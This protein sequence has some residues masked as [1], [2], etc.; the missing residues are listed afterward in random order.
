MARKGSMGSS[1]G[2]ADKPVEKGPGAAL[3]WRLLASL[4]A[5]NKDLCNSHKSLKT[6]MIQVKCAAGGEAFVTLPED[7]PQR[8]T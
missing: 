7:F 6:M 8:V 3:E 4:T 5:L 2:F 1:T